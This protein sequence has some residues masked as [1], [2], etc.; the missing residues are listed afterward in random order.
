M[1]ARTRK[2]TPERKALFRTL[3]TQRPLLTWRET[4]ALVSALPGDPVT[5]DDMAI[6][7][8]SMRL[9]LRV[10]PM[11]PAEQKRT[12]ERRGVLRSRWGHGI[13]FGDIL[14]ELNTLPGGRLDRSDLHIWRSRLG[15]P[16]IDSAGF[17]VPAHGRGR[18][19]LV[20]EAPDTEPLPSLPPIE[21][22]VDASPGEIL[23]WARRTRVPRPAGVPDHVY[24]G[25][26]NQQRVAF[27]LP[28]F[29]PLVG[30]VARAHAA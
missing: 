23:D 15:L 17:P 8:Y 25:L 18:P 4:A 6:W 5:A 10:E 11:P 13:T 30:R 14:A 1:T 20:V 27:G 22:W 16:R 28:R 29:R 7:R 9:P 21:G 12:D 3:A 24:L 2:R 19:R 26:I